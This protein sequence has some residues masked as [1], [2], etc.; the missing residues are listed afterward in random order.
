MI[1]E[2]GH[3][4]GGLVGK[5]DKRDFIYGLDVGYAPIPFNWDIGYDIEVILGRKLNPKDQG[6]SNSCGGQAWSRYN[7]SI[8]DTEER[9]A[10]FIFAHTHIGDS[11]SYG[12]DN[13]E[14]IKNKGNSS[15]ALCP[16]YENGHAPSNN[17]MIRLEDI[18]S[19]AFAD[20]LKHKVTAY[21]QLFNVNIETI[22][23]AI[24]DN[25][26]VVL[27]ILGMNNGTWL[28]KFPK[29]PTQSNGTWAHWVY[30]GKAVT[31]NGEKYIGFIN[32]W[33]NVGDKGWQ[34]I[35]EDYIPY[36]FQVWVVTNVPITDVNMP[37][38]RL[39]SRGDAVKQLQKILNLTQDGI[40]GPK[41]LLAVKVFQKA[42][43]L[44][45][46]GIVGK[47]TWAKLLQ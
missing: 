33:G 40:F 42:Q 1:T 17:F 37:T 12:R 23:Q 11:G 27:G 38:I 43:G 5:E 25:K 21:S 4:T 31:I 46:D 14:L 47:L 6:N 10:K 8:L 39:G 2:N 3:F 15:E 29:P 30:A 45:A 20:G 26:G 13:S 41:T 18:S 19:A 16:S 24:R 28:S 9:S 7:E 32:S 44:T 36:L 34:Y 22:A 35:K